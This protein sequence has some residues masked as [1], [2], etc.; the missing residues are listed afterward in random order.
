MFTTHLVKAYDTAKR[1][2]FTLTPNRLSDKL[3]TTEV[4]VAGF[5]SAIP[6]AMIAGPVERAKV[7][8]Q[9]NQASHSYLV[10][11]VFTS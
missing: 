10:R 4:A 6:T 9:V 5:L 11:Q 8:L 2:I 1:L 7:V 3:S